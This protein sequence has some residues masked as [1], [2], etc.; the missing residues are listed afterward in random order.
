MSFRMLRLLSRA[1]DH[2]ITPSANI[3]ILSGKVLCISPQ[4]ILSSDCY[5]SALIHELIRKH[6]GT[7]SSQCMTTA[8]SPYSA[9]K[10][11]RIQVENLEVN[12][13]INFISAE[14]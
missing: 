13:L 5:M 6:C 10:Y 12:R 8:S 1:D 4:I 7:R 9:E 14:R 3:L 11:R 2:R